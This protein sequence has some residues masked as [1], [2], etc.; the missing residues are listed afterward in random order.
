MQQGIHDTS[1]TSFEYEGNK[2]G[3]IFVSWLHPFKEHRFVIVG[4]K[5]MVRFEDA[6]ELKPLIFYDKSVNMNGGLPKSRLGNDYQIQYGDELA[7]TSQLKY[8]ISKIDNGKIE[9]ANGDSA[10]EVMKVL[11]MATKSLISKRNF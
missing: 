5:G 3:H 9:I 10:V 11:E 4:S 7:L 1:I 8:F 2:M 6:G